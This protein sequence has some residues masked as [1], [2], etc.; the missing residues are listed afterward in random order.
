MGNMRTD[1][2]TIRFSKEEI[3]TIEKAA[4]YEK[5]TPSEFVRKCVTTNYL[6]HPNQNAI[7]DIQKK[8][9]EAMKGVLQ[10]HLPP[11]IMAGKKSA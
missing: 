7:M 11:L 3:A 8:I 10:E 6:N 2:I 5:I 1:R 4:K 9:A